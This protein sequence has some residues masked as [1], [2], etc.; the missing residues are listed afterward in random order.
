MSKE[1]SAGIHEAEATMTEGE[2]DLSEKREEMRKALKEMGKEGYMYKVFNQE[3]ER[4]VITMSTT[5]HG[6]LDGHKIEID[7]TIDTKKNAHFTVRIDGIGRGIDKQDDAEDYE[8]VMAIFKKYEKIAVDE[9]QEKEAVENIQ[10]ESKR[11]SNKAKFDQVLET[12]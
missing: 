12:L 11:H 4:D 2:K 7:H 1:S 5:I 3:E 6:E 8:K 10:E 9:K